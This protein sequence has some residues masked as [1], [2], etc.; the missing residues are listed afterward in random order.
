MWVFN[1]ISKTFM[2]VDMRPGDD[3]KNTN[4]PCIVAIICLMYS[5]FQTFLFSVKT[6]PYSDSKKLLSM[7]WISG[8]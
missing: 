8:Y 1:S 6:T 5:C 7:L 2:T 3:L 4:K